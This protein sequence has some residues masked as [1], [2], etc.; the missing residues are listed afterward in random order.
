[1][2]LSSVK[3]CFFLGWQF[4]KFLKVP[5]V[6]S[7]IS[8]QRSISHVTKWC[9]ETE[10]AILNRQ[11]KNIVASNFINQ[12]VTSFLQQPVTTEWWMSNLWCINFYD[13]T[14]NRMWRHK[15]DEPVEDPGCDVTWEQ[16]NWIIYVARRTRLNKKTIFLHIEENRRYYTFWKE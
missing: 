6:I 13:S 9:K 11:Y 4:S 2:S 10:R 12:R 8:K 3:S 15:R 5:N 1:M 16:R 14:R 7:V